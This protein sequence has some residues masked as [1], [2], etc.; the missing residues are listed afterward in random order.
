MTKTICDEEL[1]AEMRDYVADLA[2]QNKF[3]Y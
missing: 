2:P 3:T 1:K